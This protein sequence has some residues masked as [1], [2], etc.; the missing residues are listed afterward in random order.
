MR[1]AVERG[2]GAQ[3]RAGYH[4]APAQAILCP[5]V[6]PAGR[7]RGTSGPPGPWA[8]SV[9]AAGAVRGLW[10]DR[11]TRSTTPGSRRVVCARSGGCLA[12]RGGLSARWDLGGKRGCSR[13]YTFW[14]QA[15]SWRANCKLATASGGCHTDP[16]SSLALAT[17]P[18]W[19]SLRREAGSELSIFKNAWATP[20]RSGTRGFE[21]GLRRGRRERC[22]LC[23][24]LVGV[25]DTVGIIGHRIAHAECALVSWLQADRSVPPA[26]WG[27]ADTGHRARRQRASGQLRTLLATLLNDHVVTQ[28]SSQTS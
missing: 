17:L 4:L 3:R 2:V 26:G 25:D 24:T 15:R 19:K 10:P 1:P 6:G 23:G 9:I 27:T 12:I 16:A 14:P 7:E 28:A 18:S 22:P 20:I 5:A 13:P 11:S 21:P 8:A